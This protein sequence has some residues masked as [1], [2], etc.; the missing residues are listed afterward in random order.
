V[1]AVLALGALSGTTA[2]GTTGETASTPSVDE[3]VAPT[4]ATGPTDDTEPTDT[5]EDTEPTDDTGSDEPA[6]AC[7][8]LTEDDVAEVFGE[9]VTPGE[10]NSDSECWWYSENQLKTVNLFVSQPDLDEWRSGVANDSWQPVDLGDEGY[11]G[12]GMFYTAEFLVGDTVLEINVVFSTSGDPD[13]VLEELA[14]R[15]AANA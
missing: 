5:T 6:G 10:S 3:T 1:T 12:V 2:C 14:E 11:V 13:A 15:V 8:L 9:P 4:D 7:D